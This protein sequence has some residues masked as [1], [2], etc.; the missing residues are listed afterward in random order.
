MP[1][2]QTILIADDDPDDLLFIRKAIA[3]ANIPYNFLFLH[4]GQEVHD[5]LLTLLLSH[6][7]DPSTFP[8]LILLDLNMPNKHGFEILKFIKKNSSLYQIP[9]VVMTTSGNPQDKQKSYELG[10]KLFLSKPTHMEGY[11][12]L[13]E[14]LHFFLK[15]NAQRTADVKPEV[16]KSQDAVS[17]PRKHLRGISDPGP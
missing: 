10:A 7:P 14:F 2:K 17:I 4:N 9:V 15:L 3:L 6:V 5:H 16:K 8:G 11:V 13:M 12:M 1:P